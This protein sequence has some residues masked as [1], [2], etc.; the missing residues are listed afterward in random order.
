MR[1]RARR[2]RR[3]K[4]A[5]SKSSRFST[6]KHASFNLNKHFLFQFFTVKQILLM[7]HSNSS[8]AASTHTVNET[9]HQS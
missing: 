3:R 6:G 4:R 9:T 7:G 5:S 8:L 2:E 1:K